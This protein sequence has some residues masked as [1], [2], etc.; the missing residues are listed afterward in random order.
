MKKMTMDGN[1]AASY[2]SYAF[3]EIAVIYP[4]TPSSPMAELADEWQAT[5]KKNLFAQV[6]K[7]V[8]MQSESGAAGAL[9]GCLTCGALSTTYTCSQ[10]LLLMIPNMYKI[11][12]ELLPTVFHVS[13]RAIATHALSIFG[14]HQDVMACRQTGFA[15]LA[16]NS[17]QEVMDLSIIAHL[18]TLK[19]SVPFLHFFDGFRTS[20]E[21]SK[22]EVPDYDEIKPLL[23]MEDIEAFRRRALS[24]NNPMQR[25]TAQ[26]PDIY[27]QNRETANSHYL[28]TPEIV[29]AMM[30]K[31]T[32]ITGRRYHLFDYYGAPDAEHVVVV[33]G[34]AASTVE[35]TVEKLNAN[36]KKTGV[37]KVRLYRPFS[38]TAFC[39]A[40]PKTCK[41]IAVLDRTKESGAI[42]EP[43]FMD[44]CAALN[45][46]GLSNIQI[47]GGRYGLGSK[48]FTP[49]MCYAVFQNLENPNPKHPFTVGIEDDITH[50]SLDCSTHYPIPKKD[51]IDCIFYG[52]GSDGTVGANKNSIRIIGD[53]TDKY[54]QAYFCYDSRKS[55]GATIS[56][57]RFG[58]APILSPYLI[59]TADFVACHNPS[60]VSRYDM[61]S[62]IKQNG[63]FLLNCPWQTETELSNRLP[64][65]L[66]RQIA[67]KKLSLYIIDATKIANEVGLNGRT[68][69]IMQA[70]FFLLNPEIMPYETAIGYLKEELVKK[71]ARKG[72]SVV[73]ANINAIES[74][75]TAV[76]QIHYPKTWL[77]DV[78]TD[79]AN[80]QP[81][82][83]EYF[84]NF[85]QPILS[86][87]GDKLPVSAF[88]PDGS[89][90]TGTTKLEKHGVAHE[91]P[92]W[93]PE[94]CIQ[95]NQ[96]SFVCPHATIRPFLLDETTAQ[97]KPQHFH[98]RQATGANGLQF[99]VQVSPYDCMGCG[100]CAHTCPAKNK[101]LVM[102]PADELLETESQN[103]DFAIHLKRHE[104]LPFKKETV[105]GSQFC[106][107]L[108]E[109]SYAC[110][111]CG[112]TS[113]IKVLTQLFGEKM[114]IANATG[115]SSIYG[116]SAPTCPYTKNENGAG[117]AWANSL[118][119]DNAEFG[120]GMRLACDI[121]QN[122]DD[123][124]ENAPSVWIIGGDGWAYDIGYG[125]LDHVLASGANVNVLV[126][127]SEV[128]SN[129]GGQTS[130]ATPTAAVARFSVNGK[131][132]KKKNLGLIAMQY[133]YVYVAQVSMG[134]NKQ[135][136]LNALTEAEAYNGPSLI[137]AYS[138]CI[139]HGVN[140][141]YSMEEE[142][143]AVESGYWQLYRFNPTAK[144][145][146]ENP[147]TLDSRPPTL[148]F[149]E[150][151]MG[152]NR[153]ASLKK[154]DP[155]AA[156]TLYK[157]ALQE[158][159]ERIKTYQKLVDFYA[160]SEEKTE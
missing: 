47:V 82:R 158:R 58:N 155:Q 117:P 45:E 57:L 28:A 74:A 128:Y 138:P 43:L 93:I 125:G 101:A 5:G 22:I 152:E 70:A 91:I 51:R 132:I 33:M 99:R 55:G 64:N 35:E 94:N 141:R 50:L 44:V 137:I 109:F 54:V 97:T 41:K 25:G 4:I 89:V 85:I 26:N 32:Q 40:I 84:Q 100:V 56:H 3:S 98:T 145:C 73:N 34:S 14:D 136:F 133:G 102:R 13:A 120:M 131:R 10:G 8:Q 37:V 59:D 112:E 149:T 144:E 60:Y 157:Q 12:G 16:A 87:Q 150:F 81:K 48:E 107:P 153:F 122:R 29:Q 46:H 139:S 160:P 69:T 135:Q 156:E 53:K 123:S 90:P 52:L 36:G 61:L 143:R 65:A 159:N 18:S 92:Q 19:S 124:L 127:D 42:G 75:K 1:T 110:S 63:I 95:C 147:F 129:T 113:Y 134:A 66:K 118:F 77:S 111:G 104:P 67:E 80:E 11:A 6:P 116:G 114:I 2:V 17:V 96:C 105:K 27:F 7:I 108:F 151:L 39:S 23:N 24:P 146:N 121:R 72:E 76:Q 115:C 31:L 119:E 20:H 154:T 21:Y 83:D 71:F 15:M 126:L 142:K 49:T 148:D 30:D 9:H 78:E 106:Q 130:K 79:T 62:K 86:L 103:W 38:T 140:M 68:S 88:N